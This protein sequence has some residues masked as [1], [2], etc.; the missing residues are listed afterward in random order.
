MRRFKGSK[1]CSTKFHE[2]IFT[3]ILLKLFGTCQ[4]YDWGRE[5]GTTFYRIP[6]LKKSPPLPFHKDILYF[7]LYFVLEN[8]C[9]V[10][11]IHKIVIYEIIWPYSYITNATC[12]Q[13]I[14]F[15]QWHRIWNW[16]LSTNVMLLINI[17]CT[18]LRIILYLSTF[19]SVTQ[20]YSKR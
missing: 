10:V 5:V 19:Y 16:L 12:V 11:C 18:T 6:P 8:L 7:S 2:I 3:S 9:F 13:T 4:L 20:R 1:L 15:L 17:N 14:S